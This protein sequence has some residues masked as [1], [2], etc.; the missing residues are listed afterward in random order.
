VSRAVNLLPVIQKIS[1]YQYPGKKMLQKMVYLI[2]RHGINLGFKYGIH[3]Y[4]PYSSELDYAT[5]SLAMLGAIE[6]IPDGMTQRIHTTEIAGTLLEEHQNQLF[7][8]RQSE[9]LD[10]IIEKFAGLSAFELE[11]LTTTDFVAEDLRRSGKSDDEAVLAGV[12]TI[13]GDKF[14]EQQIR[15]AMVE[16]RKTSV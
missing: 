3:Y 11:I 6:I 14:S 2:Q 1:Q 12:K 8:A 4:G 15:S 5:H 13:K 9:A 16:L 10:R 7:N